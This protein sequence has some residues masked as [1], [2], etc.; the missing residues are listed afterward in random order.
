M[1]KIVCLF[2]CL[3]VGSANAGLIQMDQ[4]DLYS[5]QYD[6]GGMGTGRGI[7]FDVT[8]DFHMSSLGIDLSVTSAALGVLYEFEVYASTDG[9]T[10]GSLLDSQDFSLIEG[11]GWLDVAVD[12]DFLAGDSYVINFSR[13][14]D[15]RLIGLGT[16]YSW[17]PSSHFDYG[18][19]TTVEGFEGAFPNSSNPLSAHFRIETAEASVPEP[20]ILALMGLG[21]AGLGFA[22]RRRR[23]F[24]S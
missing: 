21:L 8:T 13:T 1:K 6:V 20:S 22:R 10:A 19:L 17:E 4:G 2:V 23:S 16:H 14:D 5:T 18:V 12:F 9:H 11:Q 24:Q 3:F 7:G 15:A